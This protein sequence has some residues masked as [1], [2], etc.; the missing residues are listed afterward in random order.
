MGLST[1]HL[2]YP[3]ADHQLLQRLIAAGVE[4]GAVKQSVTGMLV[5]WVGEPGQKS[6]AVQ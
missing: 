5:R 2:P 3:A 4:F 6:I 1:D